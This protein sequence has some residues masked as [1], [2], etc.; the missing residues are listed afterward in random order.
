MWQQSGMPFYLLEGFLFV[1][2][3]VFYIVGCNS[4]YS[5]LWL[6]KQ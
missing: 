6:T 1:I 5:G 2:G 3:T 4:L